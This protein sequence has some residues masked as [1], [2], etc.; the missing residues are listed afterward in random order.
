MIDKKNYNII[1]I[2][3]L[4][5]AKSMTS[6]SKSEVGALFKRLTHYEKINKNEVYL[7]DMLFNL[8][9]LNAYKVLVSL[10][11]LGELEIIKYEIKTSDKNISDNE[12][13]SF[14]I[15]KDIKNPIENSNLYKLLSNEN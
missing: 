13:I 14:T 9:D 10:K 3:S 5:N 12:L 8:K 1:Y 7:Y 2:D 15:N 4:Y 6:I 11:I